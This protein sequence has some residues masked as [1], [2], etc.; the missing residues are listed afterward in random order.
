MHGSLTP[1]VGLDT[2]KPSPIKQRSHYRMQDTAVM[3]CW[4]RRG[5]FH[6]ERILTLTSSQPLTILRY[7][8]LVVSKEEDMLLR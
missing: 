7:T 8:I 6:S 4:V 1:S 5:G 2:R 3:L